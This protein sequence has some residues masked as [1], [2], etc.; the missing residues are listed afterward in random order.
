MPT[1]HH[2]SDKRKNR[3]ISASRRL[4]IKAASKNIQIKCPLRT[5][6][7]IKEKSEKYPL[8]GGFEEL[9]R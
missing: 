3:K 2:C 1:W 7:Q 8:R 6:V 9:F 5:I 4:R